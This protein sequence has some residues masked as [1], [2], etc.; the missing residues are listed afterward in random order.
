MARA[1]SSFAAMIVTPVGVNRCHIVTRSD[2]VSLGVSDI[3]LHLSYRLQMCAMRDERIS[4]T[5]RRSDHR[6]Q[7]GKIMGRD[8]WVSNGR[9]TQSLPFL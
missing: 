7:R 5:I 3:Q 8:G 1:E 4:H 9:H 2:T 6:W